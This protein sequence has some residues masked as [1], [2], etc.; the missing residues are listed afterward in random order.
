MERILRLMAEKKASDVYLSAHSPAMIKING[1]ALPIN[2]Q[3]LPPDAPRNLL[4]EVL[5]AERIQELEED[6]RAE[7]GHAV[8]G[9]AT[10]GSAPC[11]SAA[12]RRGDPLHRH[13]D[14]ALASLNGAR[15]SWP[16]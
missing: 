15:P 13:R 16:T 1:Q 12:P 7:H 10:S 8:E 4:A 6:R 3:L 2:A 11:A 14:P 5:P 9:W